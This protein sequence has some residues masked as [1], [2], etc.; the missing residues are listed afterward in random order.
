MNGRSPRAR[1]E[2]PEV[3]ATESPIWI[4]V[5]RHIGPAGD[6]SVID[7]LP[8]EDVRRA[9]LVHLSRSGVSG[10]HHAHRSLRQ[11]FAAA[12]GRVSMRLST[13]EQSW[14]VTLSAGADALHIPPAIWREYSAVDGPATLLVLATASYDEDD[15]IRDW[16]EYVEW[17]ADF[18]RQV[19]GGIEQA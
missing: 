14:Q 1:G 7:P 16:Q 13:P 10:G 9:Y 18:S 12:S 19:V 4:S 6:I 15:Y 8:W 5:Q 11:V 17:Y 2:E 3:A